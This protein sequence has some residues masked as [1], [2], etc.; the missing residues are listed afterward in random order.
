MRQLFFGILAA[1]SVLAAGIANAQN[2]AWIQLEAHSSL[3][4]A[5]E[6]TRAFAGAF[7]NINGFSMAGGWYAV[8][9][10]PYTP[11]AAEDRR[12]QLRRD[13]LIPRDAFV[14]DGRGYKQQFW[15]IG[16][17]TL[18]NTP[19][20]TPT[21][22]ETTE[23]A[24]TVIP[25]P[26]AEPEETPRQARK[27]ESLLSRDERKM[28]QTA[29]QWEG[30]YKAKIDGAFGR[31]TRGSMA[32]YQTAMGY[33]ATGVLTSRQRAELLAS[34]N[35]V[36]AGIGL[37]TIRD[38][39]AGI[40]I[41]MPTALVE[42][43]RYEPP[44]VHYDSKDN[45]GV[46]VLLISQV[47][48]QAT[49]FG[50]Y[51][52]MQTLEIV[53]LEGERKRKDRSF[54]LTGQ[55]N[56]IDSYT[57]AQLKGGMVKGFTL[58]WPVGD[59]K[60][61]SR[62]IAA[63]KAGFKPFGNTALDESLGEH[64]AEQRI[65]LVAGLEIRRPTRSRSG[66]YID[67]TGRVLTTAAAVQN[68]ERITLDETYDA[69]VE[70]MDEGLGFAV[71]KPGEKLAP[72]AFARFRA[73]TPRLNSEVAVSGYAYEGALGSATLTFGK[74][75]DIR[76]LR[77]EE[78]LRRLAMVTQSGDSGGPVFDMTGSVLGMLLPRVS[79]GGQQLPVDVNF[80]ISAEAL[81]LGGVKLTPSD[82]QGALPPV[83]L[84]GN[85]TDMTVLVSCWN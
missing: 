63:M 4:S 34:Y 31:G 84:T 78:E 51:D 30:F 65:D 45:S 55:N 21:P 37:A 74:L 38:D 13:N 7:E 48:D 18:Q 8:A 20:A 35:G 22:T 54:V 23:T 77:G 40:E 43:H 16:A 81:A 42:F 41:D 61:H 32:A 58:I 29:L 5:Q 46:R 3:R 71:L 59:E 49:L 85:A 28:L 83:A 26:Q 2:S 53:P 15:P 72:A 57:Y 19:A 62:V 25:Q 44:F 76:G 9:L 82:A 67:K 69:S 68:C 39:A 66:F 17:N 56:N 75:S 64:T 73:T 50:L 36:L 79:T 1:I 47:G 11:Q 10:G 70:H 60:R 24:T 12:R 14:V 80:A 27:S 6:R 33:K 52:I